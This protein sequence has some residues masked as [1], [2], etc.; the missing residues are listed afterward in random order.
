MLRDEADIS[1]AESSTITVI[2]KM[3][4]K[5][6]R[7]NIPKQK[8]LVAIK[9]S[10]LNSLLDEAPSSEE[11]SEYSL[12]HN[13][14]KL[15]ETKLLGEL[16]V[17]SYTFDCVRMAKNTIRVFSQKERQPTEIPFSK[18]ISVN[19]VIS[20]SVGKNATHSFFLT[21][22]NSAIVLK[23]DLCAPLDVT[24]TFFFGLL[25]DSTSQ[26]G[27]NTVYSRS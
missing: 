7:M 21:K 27:A 24:C 23:D 14:E 9:R 11:L 6:L 19:E 12:Y 16:E 13:G 1:K 15:D 8:D 25:S 2:V 5:K 22:R 20:R 10:F 17:S 3:E 26:F 4:P 18:P